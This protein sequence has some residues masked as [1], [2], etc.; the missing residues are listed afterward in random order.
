MPLEGYRL[1]PRRSNPVP[2]G[3]KG[4]EL[5]VRFHILVSVRGKREG[6]GKTA[7]RRDRNGAEPVLAVRNRG[8]PVPIATDRF[9]TGFCGAR[10]EIFCSPYAAHSDF[11]A[12]HSKVRGAREWRGNG[13]CS[14]RYRNSK[15]R[16][17]CTAKGIPL[18]GIEFLSEPCDP[19]TGRVSR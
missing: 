14:T 19:A 3:L 10:A 12:G 11:A 15:T 6:A 8:K 17:K 16:G 2:A 7:G 4:K 13:A 5:C 1:R 9:G 18:R